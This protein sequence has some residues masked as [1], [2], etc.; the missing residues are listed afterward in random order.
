MPLY[1]Y[2]CQNCGQ[3]FTLKADVPV[4]TARCGFCNGTGFRVFS[5]FS[6]KVK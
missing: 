2:K 5:T 6:F 4:A 3:T 1:E